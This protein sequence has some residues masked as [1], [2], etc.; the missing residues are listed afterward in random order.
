MVIMDVK[1]LVPATRMELYDVVNPEGE[2]LGQVQNFMVDPET[3]RV[4]FVVVAFGGF[5]GKR[6]GAC[7]SRLYALDD[8]RDDLVYGRGYREILSIAYDGA[9]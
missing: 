4:A 6:S 8:G 3:G 1:R 9:V 5:L 7:A 2:D